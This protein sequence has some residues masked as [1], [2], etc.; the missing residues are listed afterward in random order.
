MNKGVCMSK[1]QSLTHEANA[2]NKDLIAVS[3]PLFLMAFFFYGPR[4]LLLAL[5]GVVTAKMAD[6]FAAMLRGRRYDKTENSSIPMTLLIVLMMPATVNFRVVLVAVL[7]AVLIAKEAFGG[8]GN[9]PFNPAAVGFCVAAVS[10]PEDVFRYP[11]PTK[12]MI[13]GTTDFKQLLSLWRFE[14]VTLVDGPSSVL[15][16]GALPKIDLWSMLTGDYA[17]P[18]GTTAS[19]VILSCALYL[20]V[21]RRI[22]LSTPLSFLVVTTVIIFFFP[23]YTAISW[24]S[25]P[26]D[27]MERLSVVRFELLSGALLFVA[28]FMVSESVT[29]PKVTISRIIYG[30]LLGFTTMMFRYF[31][32]YELGACFAFLLV[33]SISGYFDRAVARGIGK[34]KGVASI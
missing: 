21:K 1:Q 22:P 25:W 19:L 28:I 11:T 20:L 13:A 34:R 31:G 15:R 18:L 32:T 30:A 17:G 14:N 8:Y 27:I 16:S 2:A 4:P 6:R 5:A 33:N 12:W 24:Q 7:V 29:M 26:W 9:Y 3:M 10:W 23:R